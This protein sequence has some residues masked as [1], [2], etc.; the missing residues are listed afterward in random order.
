MKANRSSLGFSLVELLV[1]I[2]IILVVASIIIVGGSGGTGAALSS[3]Q[4]I[5]AGIV[6]GARGQAVLKGTTARMIIHNDPSE[7]DKYRRYFGIIYDDSTDPNVNEWTAATQGTYLPKGI[8]FDAVTSQNETSNASIWSTS[9]RM[10]INFPRNSPQNGSSGPEYLYYEFNSSGTSSNANAWVVLRAGTM[11]PS[12]D[13]SSVSEIRVDDSEANL[14]TAMIIR[15]A[16]T[17]TLVNEPT[18]IDES[19]AARIE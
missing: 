2:S 19:D 8:Y 7:L 12:S 17:T 11:V 6:Q 16:G 9:N 5:A 15:R 13:G 1:V 18:A 10:S 14:K 3:S 4:R